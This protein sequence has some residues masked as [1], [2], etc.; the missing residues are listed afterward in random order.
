[1]HQYD[2]KV[3]QCFDNPDEF[4][5][6][7]QQLIAVDNYGLPKNKIKPEALL[8]DVPA[9]W[10]R[11]EKQLLGIIICGAIFLLWVII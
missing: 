8:N 4:D 10:G 2:E 6:K 7:E 11:Y 5:F 9:Y 3:P 1:M